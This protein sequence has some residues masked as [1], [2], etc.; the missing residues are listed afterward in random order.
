MKAAGAAGPG[1]GGGG[2]GVRKSEW[3]KLAN[4]PSCRYIGPALD[5]TAKETDPAQ[6]TESHTHRAVPPRGGTTHTNAQASE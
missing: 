4:L 2:S 3:P 6:P 1:L 5:Q